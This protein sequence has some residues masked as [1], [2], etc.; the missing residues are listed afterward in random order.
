MLFCVCLL[1][2]FLCSFTYTVGH[3]MGMLPIVSCLCPALAF[4]LCS[5][6]H[7][8][9]IIY[10]NWSPIAL[11]AAH[12]YRTCCSVTALVP[13][14]GQTCLLI[15]TL[16]LAKLFLQLSRRIRPY[17]VIGVLLC[18]RPPPEKVNQKKNMSLTALVVNPEVQA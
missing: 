10:P 17:T 12:W 14:G 13:C 9:V 7:H 18:S 5:V 15:L 16:I 4:M 3:I 6:S 1:F 11:L 8:F 2:S